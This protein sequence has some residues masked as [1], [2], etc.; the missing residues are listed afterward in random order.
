MLWRGWPWRLVPRVEAFPLEPGSVSEQPF[1][2]VFS[3]AGAAPGREDPEVN[4]Q[5]EALLAQPVLRITNKRHRAPSGDARDYVSLAIYWWPNPLTHRP[6][7]HRDGRR[8]P[9]A[10]HY[11]AP[12]LSRMV[13]E[14]GTLAQAFALTRD[15]RFA[16]RA[17]E[18][19]AQCR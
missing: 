12:R 16:R 10:D 4:R 7:L 5:A 8:N 2:F 17:R 18:Q 13:D 15:E 6:Y 9:E 19:L 1:A 14:V 3:D 11:D